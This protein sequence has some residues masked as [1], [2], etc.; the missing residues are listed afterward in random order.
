MGFNSIKK[1]LENCSTQSMAVAWGVDQG[2]LQACHQALEHG[3]LHE[4]FITG[5]PAKIEALALQA[6]LDLEGFTIV[7]AATPEEGAVQAV[8][9]IKEG[10]CG[11][12]MKG[13]LNTSVIL[14][15]VLNKEQGIRTQSLLSHI[16]VIELPGPR[17]A[18]LTDAGMNIKPDLIQKSQILDNAIRFAWSIGLQNPKVAILAA[19]ETINPQMPDTVDAAALVLMAKRGQFTK[20]AIV[21]GPLAFDNAYSNEAAQQKGIESAVAG[22]TD[23]FMVPE[24]TSGNVLYKAFSYVGHFPTAGVIFGASSPIVLTSRSDSAENKLNAIA[25][26]CL[27][28]SNIE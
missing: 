9:L 13:Q 15:A 4:V 18:L 23:I 7:A 25:V 12:L 3:F 27:A 11:L 2:V 26:A 1:R 5:P 28:L 20:P 17:L 8:R 21:D 16:A 22:I 10:R 19:I 24:I 6:N 14:R